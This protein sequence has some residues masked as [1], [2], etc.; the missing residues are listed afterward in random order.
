MPDTVT[1]AT[2]SRKS[3]TKLEPSEWKHNVAPFAAMKAKVWCAHRE[4]KPV[5]FQTETNASSS[6][7][8]TWG[9]YQQAARYY[10]RQQRNPKAG[11]G[12]MMSGG[13]GLVA[14]DLDHALGEDGLPLPWAQPIVECLIAAGGYLERSPSGKGLHAF[15]VR[16]SLPGERTQASVHFLADGSPTSLKKGSAGTVEAFSE[17][18]FVTLTGDVYMDCRTLGE[19][20][21][22]LADVL[23]MTGLDLKLCAPVNKPDE[24]SGKEDVADLPAAVEALAQVDPDCDRQT[25]LECGMAM[26]AAFGAAGWAPWAEWS[27]GAVKKYNGSDCKMVW[28]S[29]G[30]SG[31]EGITLGTLYHHAKEAS[32]GEWSPPAPRGPSAAE[33]FEEW[34]PKLDE[35]GNEIEEEPVP[36]AGKDYSTGSVKDWN[37]V[38]LHLKTSGTGAKMTLAPSEGEVNV[39]LYLENHQAWKEKLRFNERTMEVVFGEEGETFNGVEATRALTFFCDW[40]RSPSVLTVEKVARQIAMQKRF[41]PVEDWLT[42]LKWDGAERLNK[43]CETVGLED[44]EYTR[45][46]VRRWMIGAVAR[47]MRPGCEMQNMLIL[48]GDQGKGKSAF[49]K[50]LA[51]RPEWY[52]ESHV[53]MASKDGQLQL[54]G[55]WIVEVGELTGMS[56]SD[57]EKVKL[58][59]S[60]ASSKFRAPYEAKA[61]S[62]PRRVVMCGTINGDE[63]LR[64]GTGS[65]RFWSVGVREEGDL[66]LKAVTAELVEQLWAEAVV[67]YKSGERWWDVED[68]VRLTNKRNEEHFQ[69]T[70]LD[71]QVKSILA[72]VKG[73]GTTSSD[74]LLKLVRDHHAP[75]GTRRADVGAAMKRL[76][77]VSTRIRPAGRDGPQ[78]W[79]FRR[80]GVPNPGQD[81][82]VREGLLLAFT[83]TTPRS[84]FSETEPDESGER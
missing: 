1:E 51:V 27:A 31:K 26:K 70:A 80:P 4:K 14:L 15:W 35:E 10:E 57:V 23:S 33:Y 65:R 9:D 68:E 48:H 5:Q 75:L 59:I 58:F 74:V 61:Q 83:T 36:G 43:L 19:G 47:A 54:L 82:K 37:K 60:E 77:W 7:P 55:P 40:K 69:G 2:P 45:R 56:K 11:V 72:D 30:K 28:A 13:A 71:E 18:H 41:D 34:K 21:A 49:F 8:A 66:S 3:V 22:G 46:C 12:L 84:E 38:K 29:F 39:G 63:F 78:N 42:G 25:W 44:D 16:S 6:N 62:Y 53:D 73:L 67:A 64:D 79:V 50:R 52:S 24:V 20:G 17:P 76:G 81:E 32:G